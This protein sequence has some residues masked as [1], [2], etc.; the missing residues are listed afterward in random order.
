MFSDEK[1]FTVAGGSNSQ[2]DRIYAISREEADRRGGSFENIIYIMYK[3]LA[4]RINYFFQGLLEN[5]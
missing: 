4:L 1:I 5:S 3:S 2:N